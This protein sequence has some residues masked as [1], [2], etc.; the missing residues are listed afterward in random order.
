M[1]LLLAR[2][3]HGGRQMRCPRCFCMVRVPTAEEIAARPEPEIYGLQQSEAGPEQWRQMRA[4][5]AAATCPRCS[6]RVYGQRQQAG[7]EVACSECGTLVRLAP[8]ETHDRPAAATRQGDEYRVVEQEDWRQTARRLARPLVRFQCPLCATPL[9]AEAAQVGQSIECPDCGSQVAVPPPSLFPASSRPQPH[10]ADDEYALQQPVA[11]TQPAPG[12]QPAEVLPPYPPPEKRDQIPF[13]CRLCGQL[14]WATKDQ[15][16]SQMKCSECGAETTVPPAPPAAVRQPRAEPYEVQAG[17]PPAELLR[18]PAREEEPARAAPRKMQREPE[19]HRERSEERSAVG[20][21]VAGCSAG[22]PSPGS[23][24]RLLVFPF[25]EGVWQRLVGLCAA[26]S[27]PTLL[28]VPALNLFFGSEATQPVSLLWVFT[29]IFLACAG[30]LIAICS[31]VTSAFA[32]AVVDNTAEGADTVQSWPGTVFL[33]WLGDTFYIAAAAAMAFAPGAIVG[34]FTEVPWVPFIHGGSFFFL[35]PFFL[36]SSLE[37]DSPWHVFSLRIF[38][39]VL[40]KPGVW[41]MFYFRASVL[42]GCMAALGWVTVGWVGLKVLPVLVA[43][44]IY[45]VFV[46]A[47]MLG[48]LARRC[49]DMA[50]ASEQ[51][52]QDGPKAAAA[53][54]S[55]NSPGQ[56]TPQNL[57]PPDRWNGNLPEE[58][59]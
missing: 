55:A 52:G 46:Y 45:A 28:A 8:L 7:Q 21:L 39:S 59:R 57:T 49:S 44:A 6:G 50:G 53:G 4:G 1:G 48:L 27:V 29:V 51:E 22:S 40:A 37:G 13:W 56:D 31:V 34:R 35:F 18:R 12:E 10:P 25:T 5:L 11:E 54:A 36:I 15:T 23:W 20:E 30:P 41:A 58:F 19:G 17:A 38:K 9:V 47:R 16:G 14:M 32:L 24:R 3:A 2:Q 33:D 43:A 26:W 42:V